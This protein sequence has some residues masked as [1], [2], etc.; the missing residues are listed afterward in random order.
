M[1]AHVGYLAEPK[2]YSATHL[3]VDNGTYFAS[4]TFFCY[5]APIDIVKNSN[6]FYKVDTRAEHKANCLDVS[7]VHLLPFLCGR[8]QA[9]LRA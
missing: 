2:A 4:A 8:D 3:T 7:C 9:R 6:I 5:G 1:K